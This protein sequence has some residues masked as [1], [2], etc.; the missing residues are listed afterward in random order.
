MERTAQ[1]DTPYERQSGQYEG[2]IRASVL[3]S[4]DTRA[5]VD[6]RYRPLQV[7]AALHALEEQPGGR[8]SHAFGDIASLLD[9]VPRAT[10]NRI[11]ASAVELGLLTRPERGRYTWARTGTRT[12]IVDP[13]D[14]DNALLMRLH[15]ATQTPA[16]LYAPALLA[17]ATTRVLVGHV[18]GRHFAQVHRCPSQQQN[19]LRQSPLHADPAGLAILTQLVPE[20]DL[21]P[22]LRP[23]R[24]RSLSVGHSP[25]SHLAMLAA[26]IWRG[27][28]IAGCLAVLPPVE[29]L[30]HEP[31]L[32]R[33]SRLLMS[34][35]RTYSRR[36]TAESYFSDEL[37]DAS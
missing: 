5:M 15:G 33:V 34:A 12:P 3:T 22:S 24:A 20:R 4:A 31:E 10:V 36:T 29:I 8:H 13:D 27:R 28:T 37:D 25:I 16:L 21:E 7:L 6:Q 1:H 2:A 19:A 32:D 11:L 9:G 17:G 23:I 30:R 35:A 26:P 18:Y 14:R